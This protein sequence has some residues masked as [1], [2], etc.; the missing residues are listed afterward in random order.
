MQPGNR[1][2]SLNFLGFL[3]L[4]KVWRAFGGPRHS[5]ELGT[6][7]ELYWLKGR[8]LTF[9]WCVIIMSYKTLPCISFC[10]FSKHSWLCR[11]LCLQRYP[12]RSPEWL[13]SKLHYFPTHLYTHTIP[14]E[15]S[16]LHRVEEE[17]RP[18]SLQ[19]GLAER[20]RTESSAGSPNTLTTWS[21]VSP[22]HWFFLLPV[23]AHILSVTTQVT[24]LF[25]VLK[26]SF[27]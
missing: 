19:V 14:L 9:W 4:L 18:G 11:Y 2:E 26:V 22:H 24:S 17:A 21:H 25:T 7:Y 13:T 8:N 10:W 1:W 20:G 15:I 12:L 5:A 23:L 3:G 16:G 6:E 27:T